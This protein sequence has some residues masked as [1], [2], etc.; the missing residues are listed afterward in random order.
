MPAG[1]LTPKQARFVAEYLKDL[2]ATQ[3]LI[4]SGYSRKTAESA[5]S[6]LL[7]NVKVAAAVS[8]GAKRQAAKLEVTGD[9]VKARLALLGFQDIRTIFDKDGNL[10]GI[11]ELTAE[12][13]AIIG[14]VEVIIKNAKAGDGVTGTI[15]KVKVVD[16]V[17]PLE[18][19]A[20]HFGLFVEKTEHV[21]TIQFSWKN[22]Q[23]S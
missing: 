13:S 14:G 10:R 17:K 2:N 9:Q 1:K 8:A 15:H 7:R 5:A 19:L 22:S 3:A 18:M 20:K 4:R 6:R 11:H 21:G 16:P 12:E 23:S